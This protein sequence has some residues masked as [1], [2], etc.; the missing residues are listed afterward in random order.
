MIVIAQLL[1]ALA[2]QSPAGQ[3]EFI[4]VTGQAT[5]QLP[6]APLLV[7]A[8]AFVWIAA[9]FYL[10]TIWRRLNKVEADMQALAQRHGHR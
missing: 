1:F 2:V 7:I 9:M 8:Y 10:W 4:P 6:A 3:S 5:E